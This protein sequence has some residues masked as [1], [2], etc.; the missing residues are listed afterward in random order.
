M[1]SLGIE[2][3]LVRGVVVASLGRC[4]ALAWLLLGEEL[5]IH[6]VF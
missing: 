4:D 6:F 3:Q 2:P 5:F 1:P